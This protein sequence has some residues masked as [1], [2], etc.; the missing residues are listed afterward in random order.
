MLNRL[1]PKHW[2][3]I[4]GF[5][6][7]TATV[8]GGLDHWAD[9]LRPAM[10]GGLLGQLAVMIGTLFAGAPVNPNLNAL[11]NPARRVTDDPK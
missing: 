11:E 4:A 7:A 5:L 8:I 1:E 6:A 9:I 10:V 2:M 3:L